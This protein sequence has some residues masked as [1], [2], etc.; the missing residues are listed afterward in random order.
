[1]RFTKIR[2]KLKAFLGIK[3]QQ[4]RKGENAKVVKSPSAQLINCNIELK[5]NSILNLADN[6][7]LRNCRLVLDNTALFIADNTVMEDCCVFSDNTTLN[8]SE[9]CKATEYDFYL[10]N[11]AL[12]FGSECFLMRGRNGLRPYIS[13]TD[14]TFTVKNNNVLKADFWIRF[15]GNCQIGSYNCINER[16]EF[17][18]DASIEIGD[19]NLISYECN[20]WDTNTHNKYEPAV[21]RQMSI[22][23]FPALGSEYEKPICNPVKIGND[24]WI[25]KRVV[26]LKGTTVGNEAV[27]GVSTVVSNKTIPE[28]ATVVGNP[29]KII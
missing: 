4:V 1:M 28:K 22:N 26:I 21:R 29:C 9:N 10:K 20:I 17:R 12:S 15:G 7:T 19:F 6:V 25:G 8:F 13:V 27:L 2:R 11:A 23:D 16:S 24:T 14:G 18:C 5:G 3:P